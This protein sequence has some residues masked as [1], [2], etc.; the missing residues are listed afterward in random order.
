M[1]ISRGQIAAMEHLSKHVL[2]ILTELLQSFIELICCCLV[3][4]G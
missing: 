1:G 3:P 4:L 2:E